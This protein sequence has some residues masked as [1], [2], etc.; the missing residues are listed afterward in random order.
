MALDLSN[1]DILL[2]KG[3][4]EKV[5]PEVMQPEVLRFC[6]TT[7]DKKKEKHKVLLVQPERERAFLAFPEYLVH[8][9]NCPNDLEFS[10]SREELLSLA[11]RYS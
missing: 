9:L 4:A 7:G 1:L 6:I 5:Q 11:S 3:L 2:S 8:A 10:S